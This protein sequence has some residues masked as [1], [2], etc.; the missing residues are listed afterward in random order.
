M[1]SDRAVGES[2]ADNWR[3]DQGKKFWACGFCGNLFLSFRDRLQHIGREH[4]DQGQKF[5]EWDANKVIHGLLLQPRVYAAWKDL[6]DP[7][8]FHNVSELT[9][10]T[11]EWENL[12]QMLE[13][14]P[15]DE[16][17][18]E[19]LAKAAYRASKT[20]SQTAL[21][22]TI[23]PSNKFQYPFPPELSSTRNN[24]DNDVSFKRLPTTAQQFGV[25]PTPVVSPLGNYDSSTTFYSGSDPQ[26]RIP[27]EDRGVMEATTLF[28]D[29]RED[30]Q[31]WATD[32]ILS[33]EPG[34]LKDDDAMDFV[35]TAGQH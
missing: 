35:Y 21:E 5:E 8:S 7:H 17:S 9:W 14:G 29:N 33:S 11:S 13:I 6:V 12:Q 28:S 15:T 34:V 24:S 4:Y 3:C 23:G 27:A 19:S 25:V 16:K 1:V 10:E 26:A 20:S 18:A 22:P 32:P 30:Y 2:L 31:D